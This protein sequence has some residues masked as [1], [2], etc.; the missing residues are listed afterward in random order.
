MTAL[1]IDNQSSY[2]VIVLYLAPGTRFGWIEY[3][4]FMD[5]AP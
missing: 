4:I 1:P 5:L 2:L 3:S